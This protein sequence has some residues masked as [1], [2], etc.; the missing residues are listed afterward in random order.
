MCPFE[1][2]DCTFFNIQGQCPGASAKDSVLSMCIG[3]AL[4]DSLWSHERGTVDKNLT[5]ARR[6]L[7]A[8]DD[9]G[10]RN[11]FPERG[12]CPTKDDEGVGIACAMLM[13]TLD[14]GRNAKQV[15]FETARKMRSMMS[16]FI[17]A[18]P[19]GAGHAA[20]GSSDCGGT[21][22]SASP[23]NSHWFQRFLLGCHKRMGDLWIPDRA[24][25]L[26]EI[27][28]CFEL[29][30]ED[31][32]GTPDLPRKLEAALTGVM[33]VAGFLAALHGEEIPRIDPGGPRKCWSEGVQHRRKPHVPLVLEGRFKQTVGAKVH[34]QPLAVASSS[35]TQAKLW[36][37]RAIEV[38]ERLGVATGPL[39]RVKTP[40]GKPRQA[41]ISDLDTLFHDILKRV[42]VRFPD[43]IGPAVKVEEECG[44]KRALRRGSTGEAQNRRIPKE[45]IKM[46]NRWRKHMRSRGVLPNMGVAERHSDAR[47]TVEALVQ[48]SEMMQFGIT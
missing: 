42:Q 19:G 5:E 11:P 24:T 46:N 22:F 31:W 3:R 4:L 14:A 17:H 7:L 45:A 28:K 32:Q 43:V 9:L 34:V 1:C 13:R 12:P 40:S 44:T 18:T 27:L 48:C 21:H 30:E 47:A 8:A 38:C 6:C 25:A 10:L 39:F 37:G 35:G 41:T 33:L 23:T 15:Q 2:D 36:M 29:L 20:I 26:E 16:N